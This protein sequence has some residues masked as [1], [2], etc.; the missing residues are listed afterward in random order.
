LEAS[1]RRVAIDDDAETYVSPG[2]DADEWDGGVAQADAD[3]E[4]PEH[5]AKQIV[6]GEI[7]E[8]LSRGW[9][10]AAIARYLDVS[11][12]EVWDADCC[13]EDEDDFQQTPEEAYGLEPDAG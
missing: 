3:T 8:L 7:N 11:E 1:V 10:V 5:E 13:P 6:E 9:S 2:H 4:A 12:S